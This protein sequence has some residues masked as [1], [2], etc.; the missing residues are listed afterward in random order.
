MSNAPSD[1]LMEAGAGY[2]WEWGGVRIKELPDFTKSLPPMAKV[3][4]QVH[5]YNPGTTLI[6]FNVS[7]FLLGIITCQCIT[8]CRSSRPLKGRTRGV[9][10]NHN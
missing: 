9:V 1:S 10:S 8:F 2:M 6:A 3:Q 5:A 4:S 7:L